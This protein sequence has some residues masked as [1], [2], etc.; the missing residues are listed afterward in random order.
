MPYNKEFIQ[1]YRIPFPEIISTDNHP[2]D[3]IHYCHHSILMNAARRFAH[4][5]ASNTDGNSWKPIDRSGSFRKDLQL[6]AD[7]QYGEELYDAIS[8]GNGKK[9]DF[10]EGHLTSF[11]EVLWGKKQESKRAGADTFFYTNCVPQ[12]A[13]LNRGAWRSLEQYLVKKA[14]DPNELKIAVMTGPV[15]LPD[16]P[17]FIN[18]VN[19]DYVRIPCAFWKIIYY[20]GAR[21]LQAVGFMMSHLSLL[22]QAETITYKIRDI[23]ERGETPADVFM[24]FPKATTYQVSV[25]FIENITGL[26]FFKHGVIFPYKQT[27][28][29][30]VIYKRI[31]VAAPRGLEE[32]FL[33]ESEL[34]YDL[35][36]LIA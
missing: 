14:A 22:L 32:V 3:P 20:K 27:D 31:D 24:M 33:N 25:D 26:N 5:S 21:G 12:H 10:D 28:S 6:D 34:D 13:S 17:Y 1:G 15:L 29:R 16:D 9:N 30:E 23:T 18:T 36:N 7:F 4:L 2:G 11:Q 35:E 19:G 8:G